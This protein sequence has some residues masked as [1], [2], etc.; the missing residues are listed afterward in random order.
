M[1]LHQ[2]ILFFP[3]LGGEA[4]AGWTLPPGSTPGVHVPYCFRGILTKTHFFLA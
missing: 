3:I 2:K 1:I 4:H